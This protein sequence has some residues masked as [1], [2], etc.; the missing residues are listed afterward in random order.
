MVT[1]EEDSCKVG[2]HSTLGVIYKYMSFTFGR[3]YYSQALERTTD[4]TLERKNFE[5]P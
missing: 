5:N 3:F 1:S 2:Y 4:R